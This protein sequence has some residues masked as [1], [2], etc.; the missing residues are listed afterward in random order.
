M[1]T[2]ALLVAALICAAILYWVADPMVRK[3][4]YFVLI[5]CAVVWFL[6]LFAIVPVRIQLP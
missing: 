5:V 3:V 6:T 2:G 4:V 1:S